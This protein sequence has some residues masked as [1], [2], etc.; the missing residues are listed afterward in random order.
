MQSGKRDA[1]C[2]LGHFLFGQPAFEQDADHGAMHT[3]LHAPPKLGAHHQVQHSKSSED[4]CD[5]RRE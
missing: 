3:H 5:A 2:E 4:H 1:R